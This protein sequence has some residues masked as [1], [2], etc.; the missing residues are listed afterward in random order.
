MRIL[1]TGNMG[2]IGTVMTSVLHSE[3]HQVAGLDSDLYRDCTFGAAPMEIP[4]IR[5]DIRDVELADVQGFDA[6]LHLAGLSNDP[7]GD[8]EPGL[9]MEINYQ[10]SVRL[11]QLCKKA[12]VERFVY[13]STC[14]VYGAGGDD[15]LVEDSPLNPVTPYAQSKMLAERDIAPLAD[16]SFCPIFLRNATAC[17]MSPRLRFDL[18]LNNLMAWAYS[19]G[20]ILLKSDGMPWRPIVHIRDITCAFQAALAADAKIARGQAFNV[21]KAGENYRVRE[22]AQVVAET[23]P[24]GRVV[25]APGATAD[26]RCYRVDPSRLLKAMPQ[27]RPV[28]SADMSARELLDAYSQNKV[29]PEEFEGPKYRR[30]EHI[31]HLRQQGRLDETLRFRPRLFAPMAAGTKGA[32]P[33]AA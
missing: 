4:T 23:V 22:L 17:G 5:K 26:T 16:Q 28:W 2:Y 9:T 30:V 14:S 10:A 18:V 21:V 7:L 3:G 19:T 32:Q 20:E 8:L 15:M 25:F 24:N 11:A 12:R 1:V 6:V 27:F 13:S 31:K 29:T 33:A